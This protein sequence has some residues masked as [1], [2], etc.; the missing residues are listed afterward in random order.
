M[1]NIKDNLALSL[2]KTQARMLMRSRVQ[3]TLFLPKYAY[4]HHFRKDHLARRQQG[5]GSQMP[6][7]HGMYPRINR[8]HQSMVVCR[9]C[10]MES[11]AQEVIP[12][13]LEMKL[14]CKYQWGSFFDHQD[15]WR[16]A[17]KQRRTTLHTVGQSRRNL[18]LHLQ[19][20]PTCQPRINI[21]QRRVEGE[22]H[23]TV[24][25]LQGKA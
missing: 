12:K 11:W 15:G 20:T 10:L 19:W 23:A 8:C 7:H 18:S 3:P 1:S 9:Q 21:N 6:L 17:N 25:M 16:I 2:P 13:P 5:L 22:D 14:S 24:R 4:F